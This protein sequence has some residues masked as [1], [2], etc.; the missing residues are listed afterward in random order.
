MR[1]KMCSIHVTDPAAALAFYTGVLGFEEML[2]LPDAYLYIVRSP[3]DS[4]GVSLLLEPSDNPV[5]AAYR[6]GLYDSEIPAIVFGVA[7]VRA[8][9]ARL[10]AAG[11]VIRGEPERT[12]W[13][14]SA[15]FDDGFGNL[16]QLHQD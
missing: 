11:V 12:E 4:D 6:Q 10:K 2:V 13:G 5:A 1:V 3:E 7:D 16:I 14:V 15:V 8:E 9:T